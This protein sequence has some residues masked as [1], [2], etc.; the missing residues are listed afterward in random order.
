ML[1]YKKQ[2]FIFDYDGKPIAKT[3]L[4]KVLKSLCDKDLIP[5]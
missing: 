1:I 4:Y 5:Y 2:R 3:T